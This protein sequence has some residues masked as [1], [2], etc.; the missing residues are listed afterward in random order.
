M[1]NII[2]IL[3]LMCL[4]VSISFQAAFA[5]AYNTSLTM[6]GLNRTTDA[7]AASRGLGGITL[8]IKNDIG[9]MF[10]N[11]AVLQSIDGIRISVGGYR[12]YRTSNQTQMWFPSASYPNFS[13]LMAGLTDTLTLPTIPQ[14]VYDSLVIKFPSYTPSA[15]DTIQR[16]F[17]DV[18]PNWE[19][20]KNENFPMQLSIAVPLSIG[21][22]NFTVGVG[23]VEYANMNSY[24]QNNNLLFPDPGV[25]YPQPFIRPSTDADGSALPVMWY[26][27]ITE[28][29][30]SI[31]GYGGALSA[32][33]ASKLSIGISALLI[34]GSTTDYSTRIGRGLLLFHRSYFALRQ[35]TWKTSTTLSGTSDYSGQEFTFSGLYEGGNVTL[36]VAIKPPTTIKR[37]FSGSLQVVSV[38]STGTLVTVNTPT[39]SSDEIKLP[40][41]GSI[42]LGIAFRSNA[43]VKVEYE[44]L[45][46]ANAQ[47]SSLSVP[48]NP[49][50]D[51]Y[52]FKAGFEY[53]PMEWL[54]V[55]CGYTKQTDVFASQNSYMPQ[56]PVSSE[57]YSGGI[58]IKF[59]DAQLDL[60]Y[61][62]ANV[63]YEDMWTTNV[64][65]NQILRQTLVA[66]ISYVIH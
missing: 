53:L 30:G 34:K 22:R 63:S 36:G 50:L 57:A 5:Q 9:V 59:L 54:T 52:K 40:W 48:S 42:G 24:Y 14:S 55:R 12:Q 15:I 65:L 32:S 6:Q 26:R 25:L 19:N 45:P 4:Y 7:S 43:S 28:R 1:K 16:Q 23:Y 18:K 17:D 8:T 33:L 2:K 56:D 47:Y 20:K 58:G 41:R 21:E 37:N 61:E 10:N 66:T 44:Y 62:Y 64:N 29:T 13:L 31:Y 51:S 3:L 49:W 27:I 46:Y 60:A 35:D 39:K 38:D 11:P